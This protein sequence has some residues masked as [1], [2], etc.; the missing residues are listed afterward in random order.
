MINLWANRW[1]IKINETKSTHVTFT[2]RN[3]DCP[4]VMLN[5]KVL[6]TANEV[7]YL[8]LTFDKRLTWGP[9]LKLKRKQVNSRLHLLRPLLKSKL[10]LTNKVTIYKVI[11]RPVWLY[12][13]QIW[14]SSKPSNTRTLQAFQS[15][16]LRL[17][18][19]SPWYVTNKNLHKDLKL[20]TLNELAKS[21]YT[22]FFSKL[23]THYNPL[24]QKLSSATHVP[25][26][27]KRL[28]PRDL[29]KA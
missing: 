24:I 7:K 13:I 20:P 14:G 9:H 6:P 2:L 21:H 3:S 23:H 17:I 11:I 27:L 5:N 1:K 12:G 28:W 8:G 18:T 19:S 22:K 29:L 25:K 26:R 16:C 15:I 4:P 10:S